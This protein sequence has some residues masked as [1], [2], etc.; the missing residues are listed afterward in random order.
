MNAISTGKWRLIYDYKKDRPQLYDL[1]KD[2]T[3]QHN[4]ASQHP[5]LVQELRDRM[6]TR[7]LYRQG[8]A[9]QQYTETKDSLI[10]ARTLPVFRRTQMLDLALDRIEDDLGPRHVPYLKALLKRPGLDPQLKKRTKRLIERAQ[11]QPQH[12][13]IAP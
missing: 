2:R 8:L 12:A 3:E 4:V 9:F 11:S 10:L 7:T 5:E 1:A 6:A 13:D